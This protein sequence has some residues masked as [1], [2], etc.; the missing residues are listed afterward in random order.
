MLQLI[1]FLLI[2]FFTLNKYRKKTTKFTKHDE[3]QERGKKSHEAYMKR[4]KEDILWDTQLS[5]SSFTPFTTSSTNNSTPSTDSSTSSISLST[6]RSTDTYGV[7][8][9]A[10]LVIVICVLFVYNKKSSQT[11]N[12]EK[13][14]NNDI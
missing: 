8:I 7:G 9:T 13:S 2:C 14:K 10:F 1:F 5:V 6:T 12:K 11:T 4:L 3:R